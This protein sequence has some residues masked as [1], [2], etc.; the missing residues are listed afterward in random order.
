L[1]AVMK[2]DRSYGDD[3]GRRELLML[4]EAWGNGD[5]ATLAARRKL[6]ALL[7]A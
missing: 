6:S 3:A 2:A 5:P 7:F 1:L 4:F